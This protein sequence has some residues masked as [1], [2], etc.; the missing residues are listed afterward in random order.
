[1]RQSTGKYGSDYQIS[2]CRYNRKVLFNKWEIKSKTPFMIL[3]AFLSFV[4][5]GLCPF[6]HD[7][8]A[9]SDVYGS[10]LIYGVG[11]ENGE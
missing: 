5:T 1:M 8:F 10:P 6:Y 3:G 11:C 7:D 2:M 9:Q 4:I